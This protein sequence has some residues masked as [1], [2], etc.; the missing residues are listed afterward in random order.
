MKKILI[1]NL[2]MSTRSRYILHKLGIETVDQLME[3]KIEIIAEQKNV[4]AKTV[5][6]IENIMNKLN[7]G[8]ILLTDLDEQTDYMKEVCFSSDQLLE[9]SKHS[10]SELGL[11]IRAY[12]ALNCAGYFTLD[13]V[14]VLK[15]EDLAEVKNI[16]RKSVNDILQSM[17]MWLNENMISVEKITTSDEIK[18]D[19]EVEE[20]FYRL[21]ILLLPFRQ[22]YWYQL[23][24]YA[25]KAELLDRITYGGFDQIFS[26]N[27]IALLEIPDLREDLVTF[28]LKLAP[29]GVIE[30]NELEKKILCQNLEFNKDI[31]F[32]KFCDGT[33]CI[34]INGYIFLKRSN[35][36][37]FMAQESDKEKREF[38]IMGK[39]LDGD[40]LQS[41][42]LD[43]GITREGAR[44]IIKRTVHKFPL[45]WE[46]YFKEPFEFFRLSKEEFSNAFSIYGEIQ[47]EYLMIKYIKGKEKLTENSI[48]KYDGKFVNRLKD[49]LQE[50]T[51]RY[52]KQNVSRTEMIYRVLLS[53]SE[54][55]M[56]MN[57]FE[58]AYYAYLDTKGYSRTRLKI[59]MRTVTNFLRNAKHIVF[60]E[61]NHVRYCDA[62]YYQLWENIDFNQYNNLVISSNRI[63]ADYRELMEELD[64]RDGYELFYVI[65]SS[66]EDWNKD[67]FEI[68]CRRV[69]VIIF[70]EGDEAVQAVRFLKEISPVDY[71]DYYQAYEERYG[72]HKESAQGNPTISN[73]LSVY[74]IGGQYVIDVPAIDERD[75]DG[76]KK[77]LSTKK[78]WFRDDLE[79]VF[80]NICVH[81]SGDA[82][83]AAALKR[84]G[85][86]LNAGYAYNVEYGS[87]SNFF[88]M[89]IFTGDVVD[90]NELDRRLTTLPVF[91]SA[92]E[93]KKNSLEYIEIAPKI[94]M[95]IECVKQN[96]GITIEEIKRLQRWILSVCEDKYFNAHS[97]WNSIKDESIIQ[98]LQTNEW[99]CT[100]IFRQQEEIYSLSVA[101]GI[102]LAKNSTALSL[103]N[104]CEWIVEKKGK[105]TVQNL[106]NTVNDMF[107]TNI[108]YYKIAE[109]L[110][111]GGSWKNCVTDSFDD[112]IDTLMMGAE[113]EVDLFQ[114]E[115]F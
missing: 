50:K 97:L 39:R 65:K 49:F 40:S 12:N 27:I 13:K 5:S 47:Y 24:K 29:D 95:D 108:P 111:S 8:E 51:L 46:D 56:S 10:I 57:E 34:E 7:T 60:N 104:I 18:I 19:S 16:G 54:R 62:D 25:E 113:E 64:I 44:Q 22:I 93:K 43:Y 55:A 110:K 11:S 91:I 33:I 81:S 107:N 71:Y 37:D 36:T 31:L 115:F 3:T 17:E 59:N 80:E 53:N 78:I 83:N 70:G 67:D 101:G 106:T 100:C 89:E 73:A 20:Y 76:F 114:E 28:F 15:E 66:L 32:N 90:M 41:I 6:E 68:N 9:L 58:T 63:F 1:E 94:L 99:M 84:I 42:A 109:K 96:Y 72:I 21:S 14:A 87:M 30:M 112:Y 48:K 61:Q 75:V 92:L 45:L 52:D 82:L 77:V 79:K 38:G 88:D 74:Y 2:S 102:I 86:S 26:D 103:S 105:M 69:P 98:K 4:G 23:Y 85:Y 35:I